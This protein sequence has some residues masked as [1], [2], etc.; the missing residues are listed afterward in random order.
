MYSGLVG[1]VVQ[2]IFALSNT[3]KVNTDP[4]IIFNLH[5][6]SNIQQILT[7]NMSFFFV[8]LFFPNQVVKLLASVHNPTV[9]LHC[10][11]LVSSL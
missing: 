6:M 8:C 2:I 7:K 4:Y 11:C 3:Q 5:Y 1:H 9:L 10:H